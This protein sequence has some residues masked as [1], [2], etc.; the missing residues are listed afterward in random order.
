MTSIAEFVIQKQ[1]IDNINKKMPEM[2]EKIALMN[3]LGSLLPNLK[4][5]NLRKK[6][7]KTIQTS[8]HAGQS[9]SQVQSLCSSSVDKYKKEYKEIEKKIN[10][11][12][13]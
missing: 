4:N 9:L 5:Q 7:E 1:N 8:I 10:K 13:E 2:T 12:F 6:V 3:N 11:Q